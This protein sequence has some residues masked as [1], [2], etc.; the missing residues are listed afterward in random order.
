MSEYDNP[1][2]QPRL[3]R[4]TG[5]GGTVAV[6]GSRRV[7]IVCAMEREVAGLVKGW[8]VESAAGGFK[9]Y[10]VFENERATVV[11]AGIGR[12]AARG[13]A[14]LAWQRSHADVLISAGFAGETAGGLRI[15][16]P[17]TA[18]T[19][20]DAETGASFP[21]LFGLG[22]LATSAVVL[23][24]DEK[25][26]VYDRYG[27]QAVDM[28]AA[29]VAEV[30]RQHGAGFLAVKAISDLHDFPMP[31]MGR[32]VDDSGDFHAA[33]FALWTLMRPAQWGAVRQLGHNSAAAARTLHQSLA[34][35]LRA[36]DL[37]SAGLDGD[38]LGLR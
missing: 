12:A 38:K 26:S 20:I 19:V 28:E 23:G 4:T 31:P 14:E 8:R 2:T 5:D 17:Y 36:E 25:R 24:A 32:F 9:R 30:A 7:A 27:A 34:A 22:V 29:A 1:E 6:A 35:L 10:R 13:A 37:R 16:G 11:V 15:G 21:T 33:H 3:Q 18:A